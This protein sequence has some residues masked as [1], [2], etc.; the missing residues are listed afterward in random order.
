M[1]RR[2]PTIWARNAGWLR[3]LGVDL[4]RVNR[5]GHS[6]LHKAAFTGESAACR[7]LLSLRLPSL[8]PGAADG[9]GN[10]PGSVARE[11]GWVELA[12][13]L[14]SAAFAPR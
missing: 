8:D 6:V 10:T 14:E 13:M 9:D 3:H 11:R 4:A 12:A 5:H 7:W 1:N 2:S